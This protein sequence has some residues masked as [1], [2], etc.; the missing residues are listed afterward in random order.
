MLQRVRGADYDVGPEMEDIEDAA[1]ATA[2]A[3]AVGRGAIFRKQYR[4]ELVAVVA[5]PI[6]QQL[7]GI[8]S[9]MFYAP[10]IMSSLGMGT[11]AALLNTVIIGAVNVGATLVSVYL[12]DRAGRKPLFIEG[13]IQMAAAQV[14]MAVLLGK[15]FSDGSTTLPPAVG[16]AVIGVICLF[17]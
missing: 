4:P 1:K 17:V 10:V 8:N 12:V 13:G 16:I 5:A 2:A 14:A 9:I 3:E 7:T 15:Y 11:R 6:F